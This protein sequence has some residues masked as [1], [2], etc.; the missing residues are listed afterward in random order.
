[1]SNTKVKT[2]SQLGDFTSNK[3]FYIR[4]LFHIFYFFRN[5]ADIREA[6]GVREEKATRI[7]KNIIKPNPIGIGVHLFLAIA[8]LFFWIGRRSTVMLEPGTSW[9]PIRS[10]AKR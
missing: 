2:H 8:D 10:E 7:S 6:K 3:G 4:S 5:L 1:M 9:P